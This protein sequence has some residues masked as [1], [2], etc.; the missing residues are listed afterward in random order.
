MLNVPVLHPMHAFSK[1]EP[2]FGLNVPRAQSV[3]AAG[4][5]AVDLYF[6][7]WQIATEFPLPVKP[8]SARQSDSVMEPVIEP[9]PEFAAQ[10]V[11]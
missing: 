7:F 2:S 1:V 3:Q 8:A 11:H 9:V 10:S 6:P 4:E 5:A